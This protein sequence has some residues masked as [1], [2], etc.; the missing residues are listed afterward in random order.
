MTHQRL[1]QVAFRAAQ[2]RQ[3]E[4]EAARQLGW[5]MYQ[6]MESAGMAVY[7]CLRQEYSAVR[8]ILVCC[9][10]G[11]NGGD[12]Y[13]VARL[14]RLHGL[15]VTLWQSGD[16][17][18]LQGDAAT[19]RDA[20]LACG[21]SIESPQAQIPAETG[22]IVDALLGTGLTGTVRPDIAMLIR[23]INAAGKPVI[24]VDIPSGLCADTGRSLG[25]T[26]MADQTVTFI[27]VKRGLLTGQAAQYRG[28]LVFAG[29]GA[30]AALEQAVQSEVSIIQ[31]SEIQCLLPPRARTAHKG[32]NG[33]ALCLGGNQGM[34]GAIRLASE[35]SARS[36]AGLTAAVTHADNV[37]AIL[38]ERPE[39]MVQN[40]QPDSDESGRALSERMQWADV[41]VMGPGLGQNA[42]GQALYRQLNLIGD[43]QPLVLD[44][45][46]LNL[47]ACSPDYKKNRILTPHPG[48]AARLL[49][50]S[51][52]D[53]EADRFAAAEL[54][55]RRY[56]GVVVLKGA[57]TVVF[58]G[59]RHM[60]C[61]AGNPG[62]A[63]GGM[64]DVLAGLIG[65]LLAQGLTLSQAARAGVWIHSRA[66]DLAAEAGERGLLAGDLFAY[67]RQL[68][69]LR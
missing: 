21:G 35:A 9:G 4:Q 66:A 34:G 36:G 68:I 10:G 51:V 2:V 15:A 18:R 28:E 5:P 65:G 50:I 63:T 56:G 47:L 8:H 46:G 32:S 64:G 13:I 48:E 19:A 49:N 24:A 57:G 42:W 12:G 45:D 53:V 54:L 29:L 43:E 22:L 20:W 58:D 61:L 26:V 62:M 59:H 52:A 17:A 55:Q 37:L 6:L 1:P 41:I 11:N 31:P 7:D 33:R 27:G 3:G 44:A 23:S 39:I 14:A 67:I 40:W 25:E 38:A 16:A 69:N 60:I 30:A